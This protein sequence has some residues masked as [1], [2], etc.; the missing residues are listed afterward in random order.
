MENSLR[1]AFHKG[2]NKYFLAA[3]LHIFSDN[4]GRCRE[5]TLG[6]SRVAGW[7]SGKGRGIENDNKSFGTDK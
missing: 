7:D 3:E 2:I 4:Y 1:A 5:C 6:L